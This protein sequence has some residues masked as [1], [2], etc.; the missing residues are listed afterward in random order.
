MQETMVDVVV[1]LHQLQQV[2][3]PQVAAAQ[4]E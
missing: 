4:A 1:G 2:K 3:V